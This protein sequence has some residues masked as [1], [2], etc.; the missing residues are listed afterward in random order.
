MSF[1]VQAITKFES[2]ANQVQ[3]NAEDIEERLVLIETVR[4]VKQL[5][6]KQGGDLPEAK[7]REI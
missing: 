6:P 4:L 1:H 5:P 2:L 7:V 3:K